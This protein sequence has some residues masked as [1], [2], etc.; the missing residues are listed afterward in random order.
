MLTVEQLRDQVRLTFSEEV[1]NSDREER[2]TGVDRRRPRMHVDS[3]PMAKKRFVFLVEELGHG[4]VNLY[5]ELVA[6]RF[7]M[8]E[9]AADVVKYPLSFIA[10]AVVLGVFCA[11]SK[12]VFE[13][14]N[15]LVEL[16]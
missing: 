16:I 11:L 15:G 2:R 1:M 13:V 6:D 10:A 7:G 3:W 14:A 4:W 9:R 8:S 12:A 5:K